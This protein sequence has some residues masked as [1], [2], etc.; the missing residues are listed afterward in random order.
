MRRKHQEEEK[1][2]G[3]GAN[4]KQGR[5]GEDTSKWE[6]RQ[7]NASRDMRCDKAKK[8]RR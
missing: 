3:E 4:E 7:G 1:S 2:Q 6:V 8:D 5:G